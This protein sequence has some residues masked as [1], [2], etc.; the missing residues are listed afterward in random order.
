MVTALILGCWVTQE[1]V[2]SW[3]A[4]GR[5]QEE[6]FEEVND[7]D[8]D[9]DTDNEPDEDGDGFTQT[10]GDCD[11]SDAYAFPG[12]PEL[13]DG[14]Q[15]DCDVSTWDDSDEDGTASSEDD[16]V[17][18]DLTS[19]LLEGE[20]GYL[21]DLAE[22]YIPFDGAIYLCRGTWYLNVYAFGGDALLLGRYGSDSTQVV[23]A[24]QAGGGNL[25]ETVEDITFSANELAASSPI[26][27]DA[28]G[29]LTIDRCILDNSLA[30][31]SRAGVLGISGGAE[32]SLIDTEVRN[33]FNDGSGGGAVG[34]TDGTLNCSGSTSFA[35]NSV[36]YGNAGAVWMDGDGT[37]LNSDGCDW[38]TNDPNDIDGSG[39]GFGGPYD[40]GNN[41]TFTCT[42]ESGCD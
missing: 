35:N 3:L 20:D 18:E 33:N 4:E 8:T 15:N 42:G 23:G 6:T 37:T 10:E 1:E 17:W 5:A 38:G 24:I 29:K 22:P 13:C 39:S 9:T 30:Y 28:G 34:L 12:A 31:D 41:A 21:S 27:A 25:V 19:E 40:Y 32:V 36:T 16:G 2:N 11:D 7:T 14:K 26:R